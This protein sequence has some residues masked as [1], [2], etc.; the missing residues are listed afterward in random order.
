V[1]GLL[2]GI[3][4]WLVAMTVVMPKMGKGLFLTASGEGPKAI[5]ASF[6]AHA[7]YGLLPG[8]ISSAQPVVNGEC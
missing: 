3:G 4:L 1:Q 5:V 8:K 6:M 2:T 7:V